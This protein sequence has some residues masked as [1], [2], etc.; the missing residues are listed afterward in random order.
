MLKIGKTKIDTNIFLAPLS[1]CSDLS[2]RLIA[3][4]HGAK[5]CFFEM[6]DSHSLFYHRKKTLA[7][8]RTNEKDS[9]IAAQLLGRDPSIMLDAALGL[10][11]IVKIKFLDINCACP[12]KKVIKKKAGSYLLKDT[13]SMCKVIKELASSLPIP[14]TVKLRTGFDKKD[15]D[16]IK[17]IAKRAEGAGAGAIFVHGRTREQ[18]YKG[19][20]D[21][22]SIGAIKKAVDIPVIG[23]G[24]IFSPE[25][26]KKMFTETACDGIFVARGAFGNP[27]IFK[28]IEEYLKT[29]KL[30]RPVSV[31]ARR[32][33]LK[34]HLAYIEE[35]KEMRP[36]SRVNY[37]R[38]VVMWYIKGF[39]RAARM[40]E[41]ACRVRRYEEILELVDKIQE[42]TQ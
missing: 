34:K 39:P 42:E 23:G 30:P 10:L 9:P 2:F 24:N 16:D 38:K 14:V 28:D 26:A 1:G 15:I 25:L 13:D 33:A 4:E 5:F 35:L 36:P 18:G 12:A 11:E 27:W 3:R 8:L 22:E 21:Y 20:I 32:E 17:L 41:A 19:D 29:G 6:I 7:L 31:T 40:R 37:M